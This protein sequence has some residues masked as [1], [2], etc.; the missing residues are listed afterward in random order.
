M[1]N[2]DYAHYI[3]VI[4]RSG[5]MWKIRED[6]EGGIRQFIED[7][8]ALPGKATLSLYQFD[9]DH[10]KVHDFADI[11]TVPRYSL[12]PRGGTALLDAVGFAVTQEGE[13]LAA[14]PEDQ[15]PGKVVLLIATDGDENESGEYTKPQIRE[16]LTRQQETYGWAVSYIGANVDA[17][18]NAR[19]LGISGKATLDYAA[20]SSG[21]RKAY[22]AA[23][24]SVRSYVGGQSAGIVYSDED[25]E[26]A[27][28]KK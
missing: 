6:A 15:R 9:T 1:T 21:T 27:A 19:E 24:A 12:Q 14:M 23:S 8:A 11:K 3:L 7:Q 17:F 16:L 10:D 2:P 5:S 28:D 25:R 20:T 18:A 4:D 26:A 13:K 22:T